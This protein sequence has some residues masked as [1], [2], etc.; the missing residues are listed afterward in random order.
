MILAGLGILAFV[1][2]NAYAENID[3]VCTV[4]R[5]GPAGA[6]SAVFIWLTDT[7]DPPAW[8]GA[9]RCMARTGREKEMLAVA[10]MAMADGL[11]VIAKLDINRTTPVLYYIYV[12]P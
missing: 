3:Y 6:H 12:E 8:P 9:L 5:T 1:A 11:R 4:A 7:A 10:L 2:A